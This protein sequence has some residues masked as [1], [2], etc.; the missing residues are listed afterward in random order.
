MSKY[1]VQAFMD[2]LPAPILEDKHLSQLAEVAARVFIKVYGQ[3]WRSALYS[4]I[5]DL[6]EDLLDILAVDLKID[7]YDYNSPIETKRRFIKDSWFIHKQMG[8][9]AAVE[10]ALCDV[11]PGSILEEWFEYDGDPYHFRIILD[12]GYDPQQ[13]IY[14][15]R[16]IEKVR[17]F[18]PVRSAVDDDQA[19]VRVTF[20][21]EIVT[22][23]PRYT[24]QKYHTEVCGTL[25]GR[26]KLWRTAESD[27]VDR[28]QSI[29]VR[30]HVPQAG[31]IITG[32][33]P[34]TSTKGLLI[35]QEVP[36]ETASIPNI[37]CVP[38]SGEINS[39]T[40]PD[41]ST[42]GTIQDN[43][44]LLGASSIETA[45]SPRLCGTSNNSLM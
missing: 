45:Y 29:S 37:Y 17:L 36:V 35:D 25:P 14:P 22:K 23:N 3:R 39:G 6:E 13:P 10:R 42:R 15:E 33:H 7:W 26:K 16:A 5:D 18:K 41:T 27:I 1:S 28:T 38:Q 21:I 11:W 31:D 9:R 8:S 2:S 30:Y 43:G 40:Y 12:A 4:R 20:G 24:N 19:I 32:T 44:I 34:D